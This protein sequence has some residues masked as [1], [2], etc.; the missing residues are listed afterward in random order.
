MSTSKKSEDICLQVWSDKPDLQRL[1]KLQKIAEKRAISAH[2]DNINLHKTDSIFNRNVRIVA[3]LLKLRYELKKCE[4][5]DN[6]AQTD[7]LEF[8]KENDQNHD[9]KF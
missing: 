2:N 4:P 3:M 5:K 6:N 9:N 7:W 1:E 8:L